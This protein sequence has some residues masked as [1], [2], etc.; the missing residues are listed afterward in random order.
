MS[1]D[2]VLLEAAARWTAERRQSLGAALGA[3]RYEGIGFSVA[4][5]M[6]RPFIRS[7][8]PPARSDGRRAEAFRH[9]P[10]LVAP[11]RVLL[12]ARRTW[13]AWGLLPMVATPPN[14]RCKISLMP[15]LLRF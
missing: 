3:V 4:T 7:H 13:S 2:V 9:W 1:K 15:L 8:P 12:D 14:L 5:E 6:Y 10:P 11:C